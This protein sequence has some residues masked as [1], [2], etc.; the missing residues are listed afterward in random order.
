MRDTPQ[1]AIELQG[2]WHWV[3]RIRLHDAIA[4]NAKLQNTPM[5]HKEKP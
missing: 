3:K 4:D 1:G 2:N 5:K